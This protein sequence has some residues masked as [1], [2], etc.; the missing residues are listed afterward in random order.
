M[1]ETRVRVHLPVTVR[2][3]GTPAPAQLD[4]ATAAA[5]LAVRRAV[6][7]A[8]ARARRVGWVLAPGPDTRVAVRIPPAEA[9]VPDAVLLSAVDGAV[10]AGV[11]LGASQAL[12]DLGIRPSSPDV[13][14]AP[15]EPPTPDAEDPPTLA[16]FAAIGEIQAAAQELYPEPGA[17][18]PRGRVHTGVYGVEK[19]TMT[20]TLFWVVGEVTAGL[21]RGRLVWDSISLI[22]GDV[23]G[24][25]WVARGAGNEPAA[26]Q[27]GSRYRLD[28]R[29][30][31]RPPRPRQG[32]PAPRA[33]LEAEG[34]AQRR[35]LHLSDP[36]YERLR[37]Q[38]VR[39]AV[40]FGAPSEPAAPPPPRP[41]LAE[42]VRRRRENVWSQLHGFPRLPAESEGEE[43][44]LWEWF[45]YLN[46][47]PAS[48]RANPSVRNTIA[49]LASTYGRDAIV[50]MDIVFGSDDLLSWR[51]RFFRIFCQQV[52][53]AML[54]ESRARMEQFRT[55]GS[56]PEWRARFAA[57]LRSLAGTAIT[58]NQ[59][60][61]I[62]RRLR[63]IDQ[64]EQTAKDDPDRMGSDEAFAR[65]IQQLFPERDELRQ[66]LATMQPPTAE[67]E[68]LA[69]A[70]EEQPLLI[71]LTIHQGRRY[72]GLQQV[73]E[74]AEAI[75]EFASKSP[76]E[77]A[78]AIN[79]DLKWLIDQVGNAESQLISEPG[80]AYQLAVVQPEA[81]SQLRQWFGMV[82]AAGL[83]WQGLLDKD[84]ITWIGLG[85]GLLVLTFVFPPLAG[86]IAVGSFGFGTYSVYTS[87]SRAVRLRTLS[88]A[89]LAQDRFRQ[90]VSEEEVNAAIL[91]V[92]LNVVFAALDIVPAA[93]ATTSG[94]QAI[95]QGTTNVA[96]RAA[97]ALGLRLEEAVIRARNLATWP[98]RLRDA[99]ASGLWA[100]IERQR[101]ALTG[102]AAQV[103]GVG[104]L[105]GEML[106]SA[107]LA[108]VSRYEQ[109]LA[110][111]QT[112]LAESL[113]SGQVAVGD[114]RAVRDW[115]AQE[116]LRPDDFLGALAE[117]PHF[118]DE[119][120]ARQ[121]RGE[122][123]A[124]T[125]QVS[126]LPTEAELATISEEL[127]LLA[128]LLGPERVFALREAA[129]LTGLTYRELAERLAAILRR[130]D[131]PAEGLVALE[132]LLAR[133]PDAA[134]V[135]EALSR[136]PNPQAVV[137]SLT[138]ELID[139]V[140]AADLIRAAGTSPRAGDVVER[141]AVAVERDQA[142]QLVRGVR[143]A[144]GTR[145]VQR[146]QPS[147]ATWEPAP[148]RLPPES[149][150]VPAPRAGE[151]SSPPP[152]APGSGLTFEELFGPEGLPVEEPPPLYEPPAGP[153]QPAQGFR[154]TLDRVQ[155]SREEI[156]SYQQA[157]QRYVQLRG[158]SRRL[159]SLEDYARFRHGLATRQFSAA[160]IRDVVA[161]SWEQ[162]AAALERVPTESIPPADLARLQGEYWRRL[163][164]EW[165]GEPYRML[166]RDEWARW[167]YG[168]EQGRIRPLEGP[169]VPLGERIGQLTGH[170]LQRVVNGRL[171]AG[172]ANSRD[173]RVFGVDEA[174]R[175]D[176]LPP[177][178]RTSYLDRAGRIQTTPSPGRRT[179][180]S[181]QFVGDS[182]YL[183]GVVPFDA[184]TEA[185]IRLAA[186]TDE[187]AVVFYVRWRD[188]FPSSA[189]LAAGPFG[190]GYELPT[191][192]RNGVVSGNLLDF[193]A[194]RQPPVAV[195]IVSDPN[196]R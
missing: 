43:E 188:G 41:P 50:D 117:D 163:N 42:D 192:A 184:Q 75:E 25:R 61:R 135:L 6:T 178:T 187:R 158:A 186:G 119:V 189:E 24:S 66:R 115:L 185:F 14:Q 131:A 162:F 120:V 143:R 67:E 91:E 102:A 161:R 112:R 7:Q 128:G 87:M 82:P 169:P 145:Y 105:P 51:R 164:T 165:H 68:T 69:L 55:A 136:L 1:P 190:V 180:F 138:P 52:A 12:L 154:T 46:I 78:N 17:L 85:L 151:G 126:F 182:K 166:S 31:A 127:G 108:M 22:M 183:Q 104:Q 54:R 173:F 92:A 27:P 157:Y 103:G 86:A 10:R 81:A 174:C 3:H 101:P 21:E 123:V 40:P 147:T 175:P 97:G 73:E 140:G 89:R 64:F 193:A 139:A 107:H 148:R 49:Y 44:W 196:W 19:A 80:D 168:V 172:S 11:R 70:G 95:A 122:A 72:W 74:I 195:R 28:A 53:L 171:P 57:F 113:E 100:A 149:E 146:W 48:V 62:E 116:K 155:I 33:F 170:E 26:L 124:L 99:T 8:R 16:V 121:A 37:N 150:P 159:R 84:V 96:R 13:R 15:V 167:Q 18:L 153:T 20:P 83:A 179:A 137:P 181:A 130:V 88:R 9:G 4:A 59:Y 125:R 114:V 38:V 118:F 111:V 110:R 93:R 129:G 90:L 36:A 58:A 47:M 60:R 39:F 63:F 30:P 142:G 76:D 56:Q 106:E 152:R 132:Q 71:V 134:A 109:H 23:R 35:P 160:D 5:A 141:L 45:G 191:A 2:V 77:V 177:G 144:D 133:R 176:H 29:I 34:G 194:A 32:R 79:E 65:E 98:Q 94:A 156:T